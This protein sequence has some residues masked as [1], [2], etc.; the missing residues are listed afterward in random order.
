MS[1][2]TLK[3]A[4]PSRVNVGV[5]ANLASS[6]LAGHSASFCPTSAPDLQN[7]VFGRNVG[8]LGVDMRGAAEC[9]FYLP[10]GQSSKDH[11][12]RENLERPYLAIAPE[13]ARGSADT[14]GVGRDTIP[15]DI[16]GMGIRGNFVRHGRPGLTLPHYKSNDLPPPIER[17]HY[18]LYTPSSND[19]SSEYYYRG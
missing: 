8:S 16:Y 3:S 12:T 6:R 13:G 9:D 17:L 7:D 10:Y 15:Q 2:Q 11:I 5:A 4:S 18:N 14:M 1:T 19:A